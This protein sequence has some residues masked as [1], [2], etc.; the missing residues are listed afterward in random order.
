ML[1]RHLPTDLKTFC[2]HVTPSS[3][4]ADRRFQFLAIRGER[5]PSLTDTGINLER[6]ERLSRHDHYLKLTL[7][8]SAAILTVLF[9]VFSPLALLGVGQLLDLP[10]AQLTEI[11]QA[12]TGIAAVLSGLALLVTISTLRAQGTQLLILQ[13]Q[14]VR[15]MQFEL[16]KFP[17][18]DPLYL[19]QFGDAV[20][21]GHT[22]DDL[23]R[24][25]FANLWFRYVQFGFLSGEI[26]KSSLAH[27]LRREIFSTDFGLAFWENV[28]SAYEIGATTV[29]EQAFL[30]VVR[31][32]YGAGLHR[33]QERNEDRDSVTEEDGPVTG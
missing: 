2:D 33:Q 15:Q 8:V 28:Q 30:K 29:K 14:S 5:P 32:E 20:P 31:S 1:Q 6:P 25:I 12:Y 23:K 17:L 3:H 18:S 16:F 22:Y 4:R 26:S 7:N 21:A 9:I 13:Q 27:S 11:G 19:A 24:Q 10:W